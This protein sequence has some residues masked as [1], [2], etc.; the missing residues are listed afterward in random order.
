MKGVML[1][2]AKIVLLLLAIFSILYFVNVPITSVAGERIGFGDLINFLIFQAPPNLQEAS[3]SSNPEISSWSSQI[4]NVDLGESAEMIAKI[5]NPIRFCVYS[6]YNYCQNF[7]IAYGKM[8]ETTE[9]PQKT[10]YVS[11][12]LAIQIR[13][14]ADKE[15]FAGLQKLLVQSI[16]IGD[17]KGLT[18]GDIM[19]IGSG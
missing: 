1:L 13:T 19:N 11:Y 17:I 3:V 10:V 4:Q 14:L 5:G 7:K 8:T 9:V 16:K 12:G 18:I 6:D 2:V 15:D